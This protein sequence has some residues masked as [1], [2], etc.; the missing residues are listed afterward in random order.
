MLTLSD[1]ISTDVLEIND[2]SVASG[3]AAVVFLTIALQ[4]VTTEALLVR[5]AKSARFAVALM[6]SYLV[7]AW[8]ITFGVYH[9]AGVPVSLVGLI[10]A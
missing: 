6:V 1:S 5:E 3:A 2:N 8:L 9:L 10:P 4:Y 7:L